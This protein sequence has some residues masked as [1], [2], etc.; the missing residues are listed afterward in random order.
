MDETINELQNLLWK[1]YGDST[2]D[3]DAVKYGDILKTVNIPKNFTTDINW[4]DPIESSKYD[5]IRQAL[6][7]N[8][9]AATTEEE[10]NNIV[11]EVQYLTILNIHTGHDVPID[12]L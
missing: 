6:I 8:Y 3:E 4:N 12:I 9:T 10:R 2:T 5:E 11:K 7:N 1:D